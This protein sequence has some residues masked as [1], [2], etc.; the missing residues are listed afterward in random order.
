MIDLVGRCR[1]RIGIAI[2]RR[3][4]CIDDRSRGGLLTL[5][6]GTAQRIARADLLG[7]RFRSS[8]ARPFLWRIDVHGGQIGLLC[9]RTARGGGDRNQAGNGSHGL[10]G[11]AIEIAAN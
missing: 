2:G 11:R 5:C 3:T 4:V 6:G 9:L 7:R 8:G 1:V 10:A